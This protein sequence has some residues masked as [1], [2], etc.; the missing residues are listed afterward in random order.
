MRKTLTTV[1]FLLLTTPALAWQQITLYNRTDPVMV[2]GVL[3]QAG[4]VQPVGYFLYV[5]KGGQRTFGPLPE[6]GGPCL[7]YLTVQVQSSQFNPPIAAMTAPTQMDVCRETWI[8]VTGIWPGLTGLGTSPL[9][10]THGGGTVP[11]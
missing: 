8:V 6:D 11:R 10:I 3:F 9:K 1:A 5:P 7:R 2:N 4:G